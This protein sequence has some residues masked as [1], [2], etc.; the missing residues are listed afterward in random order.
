MDISIIMVVINRKS[1]NP[2]TRARCVGGKPGLRHGPIWQGVTAAGGH[3]HEHKHS[4]YTECSFCCKQRDAE[5]QHRRPAAAVDGGR[6]SA[7]F[8]RCRGG[9]RKRRVGPVQAL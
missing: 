3:G 4:G 9:E 8:G 6:R 7:R 2:E 1:F 5:S